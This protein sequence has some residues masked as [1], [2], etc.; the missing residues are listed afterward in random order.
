MSDASIQSQRLQRVYETAKNSL[1]ISTQ[2]ALAGGVAAPATMYHMDISFRSTRNKWSIAKRYS[3]FYAVRQQLRKFLKQ[4]KQQLGG[5]PAPAPLLALDKTLEA[6]FP[7]RH[8]R[9]DNN[10][11]IAER[12]AA[13][14]T[15]VQSLVKVISSI[16]MAA[17]VAAATTTESAPTAEAKQLVALYAILR[18]FLEYPDKQI[19]SETKLKLAVLSLEDVVVDSHSNLLVSVEGVS[20]SECCSICLGEWDDEECAG[21]NVVKLPCTHAFHEECLL[22]WLQGNI[23]CPMCRE[24]PTTRASLDDGAAHHVAHEIN[25]D[26]LTDRH[27]LC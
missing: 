9:C 6:A 10:M 8:F 2:V 19:E 27:T 26:A 23:H 11:I 25:A 20:T 4:Y 17:D 13:L 5:A 7:R 16:P 18:D 21:M 24:E 22:E 1:N 15:F 3:E 14:E 12:R